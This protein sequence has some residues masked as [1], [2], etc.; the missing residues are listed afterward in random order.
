MLRLDGNLFFRIELAMVGWKMG[1]SAKEPYWPQFVTTP[2][3]IDEILPL[4]AKL[5]RI[6]R[7]GRV[8]LKKNWAQKPCFFIPPD[9]IESVDLEYHG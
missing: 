8:D 9:K 7:N 5:V 1:V 2:L 4:T 3:L 6:W